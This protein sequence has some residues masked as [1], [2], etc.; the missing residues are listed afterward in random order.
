MNTRQ[1]GRAARV[2]TTALLILLSIGLLTPGDAN[3]LTSGRAAKGPIYIGE[4]VPLTGPEVA[5]TGRYEQAGATLAVRRINAEGGI[6][7]HPVALVL[8]DDQSTLPGAIAAFKRLT[9]A[10]KVAVILGSTFSKQAQAMTPLIKR[11]GIPMMTGGTAFILTHEGD[12]WVFRT[13]PNDKYVAGTV[14]A[15]AVTTLHLSRIALLHGN[16]ASGMGADALLRAHLK[17]LGV[18][19]VADESYTYNASDLT[20]QVLAI[21]KSAAAGLIMQGAVQADALLL[22]R[23]MRQV[24]LHL[25]WLGSQSLSSASM[26]RQAG[27]L[28]YGTYSLTSYAPGLSPE[29]AA[30]DRLSRTTLHLPGDFGSG[31]AYDA[32]AISARVMRKVGTAPRAIRRGILATRA[33][34]GVMGTYNFDRYGDGLHQ[35]TIVQNV[36]G[37][38]RVV[39]VV[40]F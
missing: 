1:R 3:G 16:D 35:F 33:Y 39:K 20:V 17:A 30:F 7:G 27:A 15:F 37:R 10:R 26:R 12:P 18:T 28:L 9:K 23:Q 2:A 36:K 13:Q 11:A 32:I 6:H 38:L 8:A 14:T 4:I 25:T 19:P 34:R 31:Y 29:A 22:A 21:K 5:D 24:G 40:S